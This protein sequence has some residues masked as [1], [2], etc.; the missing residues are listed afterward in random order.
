MIHAWSKFPTFLQSELALKKVQHG[1]AGYGSL[2]VVVLGSF[3]LVRKFCYELFIFTHLFMFGFIGAIAVHTPYAMRYFAVGLFCYILNL[4]AVWLVKSHIGYARFTV[5]PGGCTKVSIRLASPLKKHNVGQ[6]INLCI[7]AIGSVFQWHPF[8]ITSLSEHANTVEVHV[9]SRGN[10]TR[11]LYNK[12]DQGQEFTI[13]LN[14]PFGHNHIDPKTAL[15]KYETMV[16]ALGGSGVTFG[17]RLI[18]ELHSYILKADHSIRTRNVYVSWSV[19]KSSEL[20]WFK[21]ELEHYNYSFNTNQDSPDFHLQLRV[22]G[23]EESSSH[24]DGDD[25][26][27]M[28]EDITVEELSQDGQAILDSE[29]KLPKKNADIVYQTR[30]QPIAYIPLCNGETGMF[31]CGPG[32][33]NSAFKN[34]VAT[35]SFKKSSHIQLFC[36]DFSY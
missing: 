11:N 5:L 3:F 10:F 18:R 4:V 20:T 26:N 17:M 30:L 29:K 19:R 27:E 36:E 28:N 32:G 23:D 14:G 7:P 2:C 13:F 25:L 34:V 9:C 16:I 35:S 22:T 1:L 21:E 33:F 8:T 24:M 6:H 31:V 15:E 12:I